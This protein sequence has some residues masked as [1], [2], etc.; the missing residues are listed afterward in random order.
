MSTRSWFSR[1]LWRESNMP[2]ERICIS[3]NQIMITFHRIIWHIFLESANFDF[4]S[5]YRLQ[6]ILENE[7]FENWS[8]ICKDYLFQHQFDNDTPDDESIIDVVYKRGSMVSE[9]RNIE[10]KKKKH[11]K[12]W[13]VLTFASFLI[14]GYHLHV[15]QRALLD[16]II[17]FLLLDLSSFFIICKITLMSLGRSFWTYLC[18]MSAVHKYKFY[19]TRGGQLRRNNMDDQFSISWN[20]PREDARMSKKKKKE[21][22]ILT[23]TMLSY[24]RSYVRQ[25]DYK[26]MIIHRVQDHGG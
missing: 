21:S 1:H 3:T 26:K 9:N 10:K 16:K 14:V 18:N 12:T 15:T 24:V 11:L 17:M 20:P 4:Y 22:S 13:L 2:I 19:R 23:I 25:R 8:W 6:T 5:E 7:T